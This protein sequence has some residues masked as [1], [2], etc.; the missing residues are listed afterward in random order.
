[1]GSRGWMCFQSESVSL[2]MPSLWTFWNERFIKTCSASVSL[3]YSMY[4]PII[5]SSNGIKTWEEWVGHCLQT[6][7]AHLQMNRKHLGTHSGLRFFNN[8]FRLQGRL[9]T[10]QSLINPFWW[11]C[12]QEEG[13][14]GLPLDSFLFTH[15]LKSAPW[16]A[17]V[18]A[19]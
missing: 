18:R 11:C 12:W 8:K 17:D 3:T 15:P 9:G 10:S 4:K 19:K 5:T 2:K 14:V 13:Q 1:M 16:W 7:K 6:C